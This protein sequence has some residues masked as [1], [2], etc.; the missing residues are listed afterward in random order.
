MVS[1]AK[2]FPSARA[3]WRRWTAWTRW[4]PTVSIARP[5]RWMRP[6]RRSRASRAWASIPGWSKCSNDDT[7]TWNG[8]SPKTRRTRSKTRRR[9]MLL[10]EFVSGDNYRLFSSLAIPV[11]SGLCGWVAQNVRPIL[12]GNPAVERGFDQPVSESGPRSALVVPLEGLTGLVG[13]LALYQAAPE[14]FTSDHLR[15]LQVITSRVALFIENALKYREAESSA[16]I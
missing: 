10:P 3:F 12:N 4:P 5:C 14:A 15:V 6:W 7:W 1:R 16:I 9:D 11:G 13:V 2:P 8:W